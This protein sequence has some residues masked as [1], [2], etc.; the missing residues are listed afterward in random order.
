MP[1]IALFSL[2]TLRPAYSAGLYGLYV[3]KGGNLTAKVRKGLAKDA[4]RKTPFYTVPF[5]ETLPLQ[6]ARNVTQLFF[7]VTF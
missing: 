4:K 2:R 6:P 7:P 1:M 5:R 3:E